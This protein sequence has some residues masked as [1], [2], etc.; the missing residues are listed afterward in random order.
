[1]IDTHQH[2]IHPDRF[3]YP[4]IGDVPALL[5]KNFRL[6][7]Y[8]QAAQGGGIVGTVFM[9]ADVAEE[10]AL[11]EALF[12][13]QLASDPGSGILG[14]IA[15]CRPEF[16]GFGG[17]LDAL[18]R[19]MVK[20][21]RRIL[22][23][24]HD[25]LSRSALFRKNVAS[26]HGRDLTFDMCFLARQLPLAIELADACPGTKLMLDHCGVPDIAGG[27]FERWAEDIGELARRPHVFCKLSGLVTCT[28]GESVDT[29][30]FRP[31]IAHVMQCFGVERLV[32]GGDWPVCQLTS[33]LPDWLRI[34]REISE[35]W[36]ESE[37]EQV[38]SSNALSFYSLNH[39]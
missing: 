3:R 38:F 19:P 25:D 37:K 23:N 28:T 8:R 20:G 31:W 4:W 10:Q 1:M 34:S 27:G 32:W 33:T 2:L 13:C 26:L 12:F 5:G 24:Q 18:P 35:E 21:V 15:A 6:Q 22:H 29:D 11:E 9:E 30:L 17:H 36:T 14:V 39:S 7:E 16:D